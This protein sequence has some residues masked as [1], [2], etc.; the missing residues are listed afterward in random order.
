MNR[1][2]RARQAG[3]EVAQVLRADPVCVYCAQGA[4]LVFYGDSITESWLGTGCGGA[5]GGR[6]DGIPKVFDDYFGNY[7]RIVLAVG[8]EPA[9]PRPLGHTYA[10]P[11]FAL[12]L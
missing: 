12:S 11:A 6:C 9:V 5:C 2:L 10:Q 1:L 7:S 4:D 3:I 8:G